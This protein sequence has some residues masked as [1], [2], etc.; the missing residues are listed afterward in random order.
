MEKTTNQ[1]NKQWEFMPCL[2]NDYFVVNSRA[3]R[4]SAYVV[5]V[6]SHL[7]RMRTDRH[8]NAPVWLDSAIL[9]S[10]RLRNIRDFTVDSDRLRAVATSTYG[11]S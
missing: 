4:C 1:G 6:R 3:N 8:L 5:V 2:A 11:N 7:F 10:R 9:K